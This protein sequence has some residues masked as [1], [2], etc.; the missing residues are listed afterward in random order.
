MQ[1]AL[2][3]N[4]DSLEKT[5]SIPFRDNACLFGDCI[6]ARCPALS[7]HRHKMSSSAAEMV[8]YHFK[9]QYSIHVT[10]RGGSLEN[11]K[12]WQ[13]Q[14]PPTNKG[15]NLVSSKKI[16]QT[17]MGLLASCC[18]CQTHSYCL[19]KDAKHNTQS[20]PY[21]PLKFVLPTKLQSGHT[22]LK[23][24]FD[25]R[26]RA[27]L[28]SWM[29]PPSVSVSFSDLLLELLPTLFSYFY[30]LFFYPQ[31]FHP[32]SSQTHSILLYKRIGM[33]SPDSLKSVPA[34]VI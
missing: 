3:F 32:I 24:S 27:N 8:S 15:S 4:R 5:S 16:F 9:K 7:T 28:E 10:V 20:P 1:L 19:T 6:C 11:K 21:G 18:S 12:G 2:L 22:C 25:Y 33:T 14:R 13:Q 34:C 26:K 17:L 23:Y 29:S 31:F 30:S